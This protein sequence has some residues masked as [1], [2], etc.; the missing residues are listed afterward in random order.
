MKLTNHKTFNTWLFILAMLLSLCSG[1]LFASEAP[2]KGS[3]VTCHGQIEDI[4]HKESEMMQQIATLG[5]VLGDD[6]GCVIC[7]GGNPKER[8]KELAHKGAPEGHPGS[9]AEFVR[10]PG[11]IWI[12][13]K[14]CGICH[15]NHTP[16]LSKALMQ[17]EAGKI[18][19]NLWAWGTQDQQKVSLGNYD[20]NDTD[21]SVPNWGTHDY[22][23]YM[24]DMISAHPNQFPTAL[25]QVPLAPMS[26]ADIEGK[27]EKEVGEQASITYQRAECQRCHVGVRG[28][29]G[30]GDYR[31]MGCSSC[32]IP[33]SNE[34][35]YEGKDPSIKTDEP[36]HLLIHMIQG[37]EKT[38][39]RVHD[40]EF[41]GIHPETCNSCHNR[42]KRIG[43]SY[44]GIM[45][46]DYSSPLNVGGKDQE[47]T[48]GKKYIH[49]KDDLHFE[50]GMTCQDCHTS[51]DMHGDG[52]IFGT[53]LAQVEI[54]CSD[55]HGTT[56]KYPWELALGY[57]EEFGRKLT[58]TPRGI[59]E[60]L[61]EW[62]KQGTVYKKE[63]G[64][65][66]TARGNPLG[67]VIK[68]E[69]S[70][71][72]ETHLASG[73]VLKTPLLKELS[74]TNTWKSPDAK[75][76]MESVGQ[77]MESM[78][79][80]SCHADWAPQC[81]GCHVKVDYSGDKKST[82]WI[83]T[84][85]TH[86]NYKNGETLESVMSKG[87][88]KNGD[89]KLFGK[90][91]ETRSYLRWEDPILGI[92]GEGRVSPLIPGCQV[93][94]TVIG[95]KGETLILNKQA[96]AP[97][98]PNG[99][100]VA[101][102]DM[103]P[104]QPHTTGRNARKCESCHNNPKTLGYGIGDGQYNQKQGKDFYMDLQNLSDGSL[105]SEK[106][107]VQ[108]KGIPGMNY[109]WSQIVTRDGK[110]LQTVGSHWEGSGPLPQEMREKMEKTGLCIGCHQNMVTPVLWNKLNTVKNVTAQEH[111]QKMN[112]IFKK[113]AGAQ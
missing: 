78:E 75:V 37:T 85:N 83:A 14:T 26:S 5:Q 95:P 74:L 70:N 42:G 84:G 61:P 96:Q 100:M 97:D 19:G 108:L 12:S 109:D 90:V 73:K 54:E 66:L 88:S 69:G 52:N 91:S 18:Q 86:L 76:A 30:R 4:R 7:H 82:D 39:V 93:T 41:S 72:V 99:S 6:K 33:Y 32:H 36:G 28:R 58:S 80:Y 3:C 11:S 48:H 8:T 27:S 43:V 59:A 9:L 44:V 29:K 31:G 22:K 56:K 77:H 92:N 105:I 51:I 25:K 107:T 24:V 13:E 79:C 103:A 23:K 71:S 68:K 38:K 67:N 1:S 94:F 16:H 106:S 20:I 101:G 15:P 17:T 60:M 62:M 47:K 112:E 49:I 55:C 45:E 102:T 50:A 64:Y 65:L 34:G 111:A 104:V 89:K 57:G 53:T 81:Y 46:N 87:K 98:G 113:A 21:G 40:K 110:Q 63:A 2:S 35:F 10:D